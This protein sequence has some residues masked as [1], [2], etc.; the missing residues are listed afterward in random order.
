MKKEIYE[1]IYFLN[2]NDIIIYYIYFYQPSKSQ[3]CIRQPVLDVQYTLSK[4]I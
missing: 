1:T 4:S 3:L 2:N